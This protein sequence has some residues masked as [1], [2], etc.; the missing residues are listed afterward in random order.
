MT[1]PGDRIKSLRDR[2]SAL[3]HH[4]DAHRRGQLA[5][6]RERDETMAQLLAVGSVLCGDDK[7][8]TNDH[9]RWTPTLDHARALVRELAEARAALGAPAVP[10]G[11]SPLT[12]GDGFVCWECGLGVA[13]DEDGCCVHCGAS[14][15]T[16]TRLHEL[17]DEARRFSEA[18]PRD[19]SVPERPVG[20]YWWKW[21]SMQVGTRGSD[22]RIKVDDVERFAIKGRELRLYGVC[23]E[24]GSIEQRA[25]ADAWLTHAHASPPAA[26]APSELCEEHGGPMHECLDRRHYQPVPHGPL[27]GMPGEP[28]EDRTKVAPGYEVFPVHRESGPT[29][30]FVRTKPDGAYRREHEA[31]AASWAHRDSIRA[32]A[33]APSEPACQHGTMTC[34]FVCDG[35]GQVMPEDLAEKA[36]DALRKALSEAERPPADPAEV[37]RLRTAKSRTILQAQMW[38][39]EAKTQRSIVAG[40]LSLL[41]IHQRP[42]YEEQQVCE[43]LLDRV[44]G[45]LR[46]DPPLRILGGRGARSASERQIEHARWAVQVADQGKFCGDSRDL[47]DYRVIVRVHGD[48]P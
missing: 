24:T 39:M 3:A 17:A 40:I 19:E 12:P 44:V 11:G 29:C 30:W 28:D 23:P 27:D 18:V 9:P 42:G 14:A 16:V 32:A 7:G 33:P 41:G 43:W 4:A 6:E 36:R 5:A 47:A 35:C 8:E 21:G 25:V 31:V 48:A 46:D 22:F 38:A 13:V 34:R 1:S 2:C 10:R 20:G 45:G 37:E 15:T 26:P